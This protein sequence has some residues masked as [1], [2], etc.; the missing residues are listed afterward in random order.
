M[1]V[2][3]WFRFVAGLL[4][5]FGVALLIIPQLLVPI[6]GIENSA[7]TNLLLRFLG[8]AWIGLGVILWMARDTRSNRARHAILVGGCV[9]ALLDL[10]VGLWGVW[11]GVTGVNGWINVVLAGLLLLGFGYFVQKGSA[12]A[13][14]STKKRKRRS[15]VE[16]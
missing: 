8:A 1:K 16:G 10:L 4:V 7:E 14:K 13:S 6:F 9:A 3:T 2:Q 15:T 11:G 12:E 5:A